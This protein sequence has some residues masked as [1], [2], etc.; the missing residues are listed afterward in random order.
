[1]KIYAKF[2]LLFTLFAVT[3]CVPIDYAA[4]DNEDEDDYALPTAEREDATGPVEHDFADDPADGYEDDDLKWYNST[5]VV[6]EDEDWIFEIDRYVVSDFYIL[7]NVR[8]KFLNWYMYYR[9]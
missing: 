3:T 7:K 5:I 6:L 2:V 8:Y 9:L 4:F 1:M